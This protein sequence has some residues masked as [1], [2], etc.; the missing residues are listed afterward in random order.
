MIGAR[1]GPNEVVGLVGAGG[2]GE[3][4]RVRDMPPGNGLAVNALSYSLVNLFTYSVT[5]R[6]LG[7]PAIA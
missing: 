5:S 1:L 2:I 4:Y 7:L 3:V 6:I